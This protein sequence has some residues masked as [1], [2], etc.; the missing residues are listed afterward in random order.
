MPS[1]A[2]LRGSV[3]V[4]LMYIQNK[5]TWSQLQ[6][7][8][9]LA[10]LGAQT[11][12]G[13]VSEKVKWPSTGCGGKGKRTQGFD[14]FGEGG[15]GVAL[16]VSLGNFVMFLVLDIPVHATEAGAERTCMWMW[17]QARGG[18]GGVLG[19]Q[20]CFVVRPKIFPLLWRETIQDIKV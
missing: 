4:L 17:R 8:T 19:R 5:S 9:G 13:A 14:S 12:K 1:S 15:D 3:C 11:S 10:C 18:R 16:Y 2:L 6:P 20:L 7:A